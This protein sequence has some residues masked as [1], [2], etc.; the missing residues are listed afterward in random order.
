V[1][2]LGQDQGVLQV[3]ADGGTTADTIAVNINLAPGSDGVVLAS[4]NGG[5]GNDVLTLAV[6][7]Q[8]PSDTPV[9]VATVDGG[10]GFNHCFITPN[11]TATNCQVVTLI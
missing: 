4:E 9:V 8:Q 3:R 6:R 7:K 1:N 2:F 11:V 10:P 5:A